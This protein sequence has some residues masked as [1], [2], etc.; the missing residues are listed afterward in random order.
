MENV[1]GTRIEDKVVL[2]DHYKFISN[3]VI[4]VTKINDENHFYSN[5]IF[6]E[7]N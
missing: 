2:K 5:T 1:I 3:N 7:W 6:E 4:P